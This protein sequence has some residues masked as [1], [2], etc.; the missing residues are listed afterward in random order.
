VAASFQHDSEPSGSMQGG[1]FFY[2]LSDSQDG[3]CYME[4]V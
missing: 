1:E 2:Y 3:L 4:L